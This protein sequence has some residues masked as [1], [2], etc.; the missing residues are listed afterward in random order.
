DHLGPN[1]RL[2]V[3]DGLGRSRAY[4]FQ[5]K[6][7]R[8]RVGVR[9]FDCVDVQRG[10]FPA[11]INSGLAPRQIAGKKTDSEEQGCGSLNLFRSHGGFFLLLKDNAP[12]PAV[13]RVRSLEAD[14]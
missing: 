14:D 8:P 12:Y 7:R 9:S 5:W 3:A 11:L 2:I 1:T 13:T 10:C 4:G 6:L